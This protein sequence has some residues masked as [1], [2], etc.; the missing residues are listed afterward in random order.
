MKKYLFSSV[1]AMLILGCGDSAVDK[2][3]K[4]TLPQ[5]KSMNIETA[6]K[7]SKICSKISW[8]DTSKDGLVSAS[9]TCEVG[10][11]VLKAEFDAQ[12]AKFLKAQEEAKAQIKEKVENNLKILA[13]R[14]EISDKE[15]LHE[16]AMKFCEYD[17]KEKEN[18][19]SAPV[20]CDETGLNGSVDGLKAGLKD[21]EKKSYC[22]RLKKCG[23]ARKRACEG[24]F[25]KAGG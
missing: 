20:K 7:T 1:L 8:D 10:A 15:K 23:L 11:D 22:K 19:F 14:Y 13:E 21:Y 24:L 5:F 16:I 18:L 3:K 2:V 12:N 4:Y 9:L 17:E 25:Y 6:I